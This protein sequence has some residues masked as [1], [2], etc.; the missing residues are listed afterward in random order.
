MS[1]LSDS[2]NKIIFDKVRNK[3]TNKLNFV[4]I[5]ESIAKEN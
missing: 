4:S 2:Y 1:V 3:I 5:T